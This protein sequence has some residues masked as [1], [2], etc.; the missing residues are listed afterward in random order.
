MMEMGALPAAAGDWP[1]PPAAAA[2]SPAAPPLAPLAPPAAAADFFAAALAL[3]ASH[4]TV[5]VAVTV[6]VLGY[7]GE[8]EVAVSVVVEVGSGVWE[9]M[10]V[11]KVV[12]VSVSVGCQVAV[13]RGG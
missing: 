13:L 2:G 7:V 12:S 11:R 3:L 1:A 8:G 9:M 5:V 4:G 10:T 6:C